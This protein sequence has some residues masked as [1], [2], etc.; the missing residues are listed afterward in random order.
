[1]K[2]IFLKFWDLWYQ[3]RRA[4]I[5]FFTFLIFKIR[6]YLFEL[7]FVNVLAELCLF[8]FFGALNLIGEEKRLI[9]LLKGKIKSKQNIFSGRVNCIKAAIGFK[10]KN[11]CNIHNVFGCCWQYMQ[12]KVV[13][14]PVPQSSLLGTFFS[15]FLAFLIINGEKTFYERSW[16]Q[17]PVR[18]GFSLIKIKQFFEMNPGQDLN[19]HAVTLLS[20]IL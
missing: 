1:M 3:R 13:H 12:N 4:L 6:C 18:E 17:F 11:P 7:Q 15:W 14:H 16:V 10:L 2:V 9:A 20:D 19:Y 8:I 5:K